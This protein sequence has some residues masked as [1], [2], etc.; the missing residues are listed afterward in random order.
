MVPQ[1]ASV[2]FATWTAKKDSSYI[3]LQAFWLTFCSDPECVILSN[4]VNGLYE[5][6][7]AHD[8]GATSVFWFYLFANNLD[9]QDSVNI[10]SGLSWDQ[11]FPN[12]DFTLL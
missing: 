7:I 12:T 2:N 4:V 8:F 6:I 5:L 3:T 9:I 1:V 11:Y 10:H